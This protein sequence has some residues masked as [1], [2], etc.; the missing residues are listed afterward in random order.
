MRIQPVQVQRGTDTR[1]MTERLR[2]V[3]HLFTG[4]G[5]F[6]REHA[7]VV[8]VGE[9]IVE[10]RESKFVQVGDVNVVGCRLVLLA[11]GTT[12]PSHPP[13]PCV[14]VCVCVGRLG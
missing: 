8:G 13:S 10:M 12:F 14:C 7:Q 9:N 3:A 2:H 5:D 6:L 11:G 1:Q 4:D